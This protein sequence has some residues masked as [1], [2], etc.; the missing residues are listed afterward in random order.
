MLSIEGLLGLVNW[1]YS[2]DKGGIRWQD[3]DNERAAGRPGVWCP[4]RTRSYE[5]CVTV[6]RAVFT[7]CLVLL[8]MWRE[9]SG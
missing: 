2:L 4:E 8:H 3:A 6:N 5:G 7:A 9:R 1:R